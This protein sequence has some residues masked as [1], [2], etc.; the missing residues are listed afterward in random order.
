MLMGFSRLT[1][2]LRQFTTS[3][4]LLAPPEYSTGEPDRDDGR[5]E[6]TGLANQNG[7]GLDVFAKR[8]VKDFDGKT[9]EL[10]KQWWQRSWLQ[11]P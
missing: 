11:G 7:R 5:T 6:Q 2:T 1:T 4:I 9:M 10:C 8:P 3:K